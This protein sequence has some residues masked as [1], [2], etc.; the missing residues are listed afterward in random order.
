[1]TGRAGTAK[2]AVIT[3]LVTMSIAAMSLASLPASAATISQIAPFGN[4][5]DVASSAAFTD[6]LVTSGDVYKRQELLSNF[7]GAN[8]PSAVLPSNTV[9][10]RLN[11]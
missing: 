2:V 5:V 6:N 10:K 11:S 3:V 8:H 7:S 1:M 4:S 9:F